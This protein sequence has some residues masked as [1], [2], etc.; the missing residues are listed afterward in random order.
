[1]NAATPARIRRCRRFHVEM[2]HTLSGHDGACAH[3][4]GH[5][6]ALGVTVIGRP[7]QDPASPRLGRIMDFAELEQLVHEQVIERFDHV[8]VLNARERGPFDAGSSPIFGRL[9]FTP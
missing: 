7:V 1:M 4:H 6:Y 8:R 3:L 9:L 2:A 5:S